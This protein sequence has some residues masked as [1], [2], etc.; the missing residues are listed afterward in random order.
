MFLFLTWVLLSV[1]FDDLYLGQ[2]VGILKH[3][4]ISPVAPG[5][6][7]SA[8]NQ[9]H[10]H[11]QIEVRRSMFVDVTQFTGQPGDIVR[12]GT[13]VIRAGGVGLSTAQLST[14]G[15][16]FYIGLVHLQTS[17]VSKYTSHSFI[18]T[19]TLKERSEKS[20]MKPNLMQMKH[21][22]LYRPHFVCTR[23]ETGYISLHLLHC[24]W[25]S[26]QLSEKSSWW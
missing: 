25:L 12:G 19:V 23:L 8:V 3:G 16:T 22:C 10:V 1:F 6:T 20:K 17:F 4:V 13:S 21:P 5:G 18:Q 9:W 11:V 2:H 7:C 24:F 14:L 26:G 15:L